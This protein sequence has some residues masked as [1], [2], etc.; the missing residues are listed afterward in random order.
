M[1]P[2]LA[3]PR[4]L[5]RSFV[6]ESLRGVTQ[7]WMT[8][9][10]SFPC[11]TTCVAPQ[12]TQLF[13]SGVRVALISSHRLLVDKLT[14]RTC[15]FFFRIPAFGYNQNVRVCNPC[16][17]LL[18]E[19]FC[20]KPIACTDPTWLKNVALIG[21]EVELFALWRLHCRRRA[22]CFNVCKISLYPPS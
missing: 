12:A 1:Q 17:A 20:E 6:I 15:L 14:T 19:M 22:V 16:F 3:G 5:R 11:G 8:D 21:W 9:V 2:P 13:S 10:H 7:N 4:I 18:D